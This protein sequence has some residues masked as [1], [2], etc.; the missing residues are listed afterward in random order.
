[1]MAGDFVELPPLEKDIFDIESIP[2]GLIRYK[3][4]GGRVNWF[5]CENCGSHIL[6]CAPPVNDP[7]GK[8]NWLFSLGTFYPLALNDGTKTYKVL[9]HMFVNYGR[10]QGGLSQ[11]LQD[12]VPRYI[13]EGDAKESLA[14][15]NQE[16]T[17]EEKQEIQRAIEAP[18]MPLRCHCGHVKLNVHRPSSAPIPDD[19]RN[20]KGLRRQ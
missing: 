4:K 13:N 17:K 2:T 15:Q 11:Y 6:Q 19:D 18:T 12:D 3:K 10:D 7:Q 9:K 5:F 8:L 20:V 16:A 1:M 14:S